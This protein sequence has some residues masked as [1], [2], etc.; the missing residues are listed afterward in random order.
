MEKRIKFIEKKNNS[1]QY[2]TNGSEGCTPQQFAR[3]CKITGMAATNITLEASW[4]V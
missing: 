1:T 2:N 3:N 4:K